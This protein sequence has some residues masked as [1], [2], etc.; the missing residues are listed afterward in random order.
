MKP[1]ADPPAL[2]PV[3]GPVHGPIDMIPAT[4][5]LTGRGAAAWEIMS[6]LPI[7]EGEHAGKLIG[8][9]SPP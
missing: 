8:E 4:R 3:T 7:T 6:R 9:N 1:F 5:D 2:F